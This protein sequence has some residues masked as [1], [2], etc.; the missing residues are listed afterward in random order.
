[1]T[2]PETLCTACPTKGERKDVP[3]IS[4]TVTA[5]TDEAKTAIVALASL[6]VHSHRCWEVAVIL[7]EGEFEGGCANGSVA[8]VDLF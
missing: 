6:M 1:M 5:A 8:R 4:V 2:T 3:C 7:A